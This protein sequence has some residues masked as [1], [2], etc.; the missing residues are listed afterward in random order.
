MCY[1]TLIRYVTSYYSL[2]VQANPQRYL[3]HLTDRY[4]DVQQYTQLVLET[5]YWGGKTLFTY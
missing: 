1:F 2:Q 4:V 3:S 5:G